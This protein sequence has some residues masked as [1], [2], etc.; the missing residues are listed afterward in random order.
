MADTNPIRS[1]DGHAVQCPSKYVYQLYDVS[2]PDAGRT[3]DVVM[4]K[5]RIGQCV[6]LELEWANVS[7]AQLSAILQRFNPEYIT[8]NYLDG[9]N[10]GYRTCRFYVGDR[11][12]PMYNAAM[13]LWENVAFNIIEVGGDR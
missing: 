12:A 10:G 13:D 11:S 5:N 2:D 1:I 7:T 3:E 4:H 9:L 8:V 6:K